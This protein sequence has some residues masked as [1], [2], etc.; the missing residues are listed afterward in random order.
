[1]TPAPGTGGTPPTCNFNV[2]VGLDVLVFFGGFL[3][4]MSSLRFW[5]SASFTSGAVEKE[6]VGMAGYGG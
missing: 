3:S 1:M 2:L 4:H 6:E 5:S